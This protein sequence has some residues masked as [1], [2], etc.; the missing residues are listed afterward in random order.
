MK[1]FFAENFE[2][3]PTDSQIQLF[4]DVLSWSDEEVDLG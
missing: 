2:Y 1:K 4:Q 3:D